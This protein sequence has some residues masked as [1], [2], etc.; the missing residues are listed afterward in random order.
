MWKS[1]SFYHLSVPYTCATR[2][3]K[4]KM[5]MYYFCNIVNSYVSTVFATAESAL[6]P[7]WKAF[8]FF[9]SPL[10]LSLW[11][12][13]IQFEAMIQER[14]SFPFTTH[15]NSNVSA[16]HALLCGEMNK[17]LQLACYS[18]VLVKSSKTLIYFTY[19]CLCGICIQLHT[20]GSL[21]FLDW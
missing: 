10:F 3:W 12:I 2:V 19:Y 14:C 20:Y 4:Q 5:R 7:G 21:L 16:L 9:F 1:I 11:I 8:A 15:S 18:S 6:I 13:S 17:S